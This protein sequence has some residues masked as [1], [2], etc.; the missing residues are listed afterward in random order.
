MS[1]RGDPTLSVSCSDKLTRWLQIG[2]QGALLSLILAEPIRFSSFTITKNVPF[3]KDALLR[4]LFGRLQSACKKIELFVGQ[5]DVT[6]D[7]NKRNDKRPSANSIV[8]YKYQSSSVQEVAAGGR[9][10]G[11]TKKLKGDPKSRLSISKVE[12]FISFIQ[13][14]K[15]ITEVPKRFQDIEKRSY[16]EVKLLASEYQYN[17]LQLKKDG[18]RIWTVKDKALLGFHVT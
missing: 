4:C 2:L 7:H 9:R 8:W 1:G 11:I 12:L 18:F 5:A 10:L 3:S 16:A 15:S 17:W 13:T 6:F 14:V